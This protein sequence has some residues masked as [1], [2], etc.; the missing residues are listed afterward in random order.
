MTGG[1][2][3]FAGYTAERLW[4]A[5]QAPHD[6]RYTVA[7]RALHKHGSRPGSAFPPPSGPPAVI[8]ARAEA[9]VRQ[10]LTDPRGSVHTYTHP[11]HGRI[12]DIVGSD[13]R[14]VRFSTSG[15]FITFLE[16]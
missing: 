1:G 10:I 13:G 2:G 11:R 8:N 7:G 5:A 16:P 12:I 9:I 15:D 4:Q 14:G 6:A 3:P